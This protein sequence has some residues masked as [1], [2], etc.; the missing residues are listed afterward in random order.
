ML[1]G[2]ADPARLAALVDRGAVDASGISSLPH[3]RDAILHLP[4]EAL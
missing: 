3:M 4:G 2:V 1:N